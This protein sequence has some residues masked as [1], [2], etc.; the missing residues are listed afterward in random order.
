MKRKLI[1]KL[2]APRGLPVREPH[3]IVQVGLIMYNNSESLITVYQTGSSDKSRHSLQKLKQNHVKLRGTNIYILSQLP[4]TQWR[5]H[6]TWKAWRYDDRCASTPWASLTGSSSCWGTS[7]G[8][9]GRGGGGR[10][11]GGKVQGW[12][13]WNMSSAFAS[14]MKTA[15]TKNSKLKRW[16]LTQRL[17]NWKILGQKGWILSM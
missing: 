2:R 15:V 10:G 8:G 14:L 1:V 6:R 16:R 7:W 13:G 17:K 3:Y 11:E 12:K 5:R 9:G 4:L